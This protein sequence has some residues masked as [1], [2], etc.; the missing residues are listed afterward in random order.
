MS[1]PRAVL[2][3]D[4]ESFAHTPAYRSA[5][6]TADDPESVGP[7]TM[8]RLLATLAEHDADATFFTVS[9][10]AQRHPDLLAAAAEADH[11]IA[12]HTHTH[13]LLTD[14]TPEERR[15]ELER[16][17]AVLESVTGAEVEGF[18]APVF[19]FA[20]DHFDLLDET[21]Y[22]YDSSVAPCRRIPGFYGGE[23]DVQ[24][25]TLASALQSGAPDS[26]TEL[27]IAVMPGLGLPLTGTWIRF[28]GVRYT[29]LGM[30]LLARRGITP[31]LYVH[32]WELSALPSVD[33]VPERVYVRTGAYMWRAVEYLLSSE[34]TFV[35][36]REVVEGASANAGATDRDGDAAAGGRPP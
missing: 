31:V 34:F 20:D 1:E 22:S 28:F 14:C 2:S 13:R 29:Y 6:G 17:K 24:E 8:D 36:A 3:V 18:R 4:F 9:A 5:G 26:V 23:Y 16:S 27:P 30:K 33:G 32:P 11:E 12:S 19:D 10:V 25:P 7:E 21:G 15:E 35:T